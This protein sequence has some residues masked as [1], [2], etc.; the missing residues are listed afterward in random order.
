MLGA[1]YT[2]YAAELK[3]MNAAIF[4]YVLPEGY[5]RDFF[6]SIQTRSQIATH[7]RGLSLLI[8]A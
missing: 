6:A 2:K 1:Y 4:A 3:A 7:P 5:M 8:L